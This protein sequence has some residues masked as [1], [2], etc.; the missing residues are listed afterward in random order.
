[1]AGWSEYLLAFTVFFISHGIPVRPAVRAG[2]IG[3]LGPRGFSLGYSALSIIVLVWLF[4]AAGRAPYVGLWPSAPW[5]AWVPLLL[6]ALASAILALALARPNPLSFGGA[7]NARFDPAKAGIIGW[8]RHPLLAAIAIWAAA[9]IVPNG[10]LAHALLFAVFCGFALVGMRLI[11]RRKRRQM[12]SDWEH[13]V[14]TR[15]RITL[16]VD[17]TMRL[18]LGLGVYVLLLWLHGPVIGVYP[19]P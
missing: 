15:R 2:L 14:A 3:W 16:T 13:L 9:H 18:A 11:D 19:W 5:Q 10:D 7:R 8:I 12:G 1:M 6:M 17:G 4:V